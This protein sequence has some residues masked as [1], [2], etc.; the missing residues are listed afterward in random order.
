MREAVFAEIVGGDG[1]DAF[2][3]PTSA[4][5]R[6]GFEEL[7]L[8]VNGGLPAFIADDTADSAGG[9]QGDDGSVGQR[10]RA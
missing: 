1:P 7:D 5:E 10:R 4:P 9:C 8:D 3:G 6:F 2:E